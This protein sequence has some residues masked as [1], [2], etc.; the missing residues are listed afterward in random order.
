MMMMIHRY[1]LYTCR[2]KVTTDFMQVLTKDSRIWQ[3]ICEVVEGDGRNNAGVDN[4]TLN[5]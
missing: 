4:A 3:K 2:C 1:R 5:K